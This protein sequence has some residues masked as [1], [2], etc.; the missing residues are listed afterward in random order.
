MGELLYAAVSNFTLVGGV[1]AEIAHIKTLFNVLQ[2][3]LNNFLKF[4]VTPCF[5]HW[6][7]M[8]SHKGFC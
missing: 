8:L 5:L 6:I 2:E 3:M 7:F 4:M 1:D